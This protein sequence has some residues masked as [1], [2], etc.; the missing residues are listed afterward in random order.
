MPVANAHLGCHVRRLKNINF[1]IFR[2]I[3]FCGCVYYPC[4]DM[5]R[6]ISGYETSSVAHSRIVKAHTVL[7]KLVTC[8]EISDSEIFRF[9]NNDIQKN[10]IYL[11]M[12]RNTM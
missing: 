12:F 10:S 11:E 1:N 5:L 3:R 2:D 8:M 6:A 7:L 4:R 9:G